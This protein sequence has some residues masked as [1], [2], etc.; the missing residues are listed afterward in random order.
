MAEGGSF[1]PSIHL[2]WHFEE[3]DFELARPVYMQAQ[4]ATD[5]AKGIWTATWESTG[6]PQYFSGGKAPFVPEVRSQTAGFTVNAGTITQLMLSYLA[7]GF[8][9]FGFWSWNPRTVGWEAGEFA[10]TDR[11][12][13]VTPRAI[14]AGQIGKAARKYHREL[15]QAH[16]EPLVGVMVDWENEAMWAAMAVA[17]RDKFKSEPVHARIGVS[18]ALINANVPWEYV[19]PANL[20]AG[21]GGRYRVIYLPACICIP[22]Q[23]QQL[24]TDYV[25]DGGRVVLDMPG[26]YYDE[27]GQLLPTGP[28]S[29][30]EKTFGAVL[31]EYTY[32][33]NI[34]QAID[35][36]PLEGFAAELTPTRAKTLATYADGR[37]A[38]TQSHTGTGQAV[39]IGAQTALMCLRPGNT[40]IESLL[41]RYTLGS[42]QSPYACE[43]ALAYRLAA[44]KADH[45]F[46]IND[47]PARSVNLD[48]RD[49]HYSALIDAVTGQSLSPGKPVDL[50]AFGGRWLRF[51]KQE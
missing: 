12:C 11:N 4:L 29:W 51:D 34:P 38:I 46:L 10:L 44:P 37:P 23:M 17:G 20:L 8:K 28:G 9:G 13:D 24:L 35:G 5:W 41:I 7:A 1:Y 45:Y 36:I 19:T 2:A 21:L 32:A 18:R 47:G 6:G 3:V 50:E 16:K 25:T 15:W 31:N 48:T 42:Y 27:F 40:N 49:Y 14:R 39:I 26:A 33:R 30:F 43:G 22:A